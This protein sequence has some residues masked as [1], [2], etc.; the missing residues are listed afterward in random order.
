M[1]PKPKETPN[2]LLEF[3]SQLDPGGAGEECE[4]HYGCSCVIRKGQEAAKMLIAVQGIV[5]VGAPAAAAPAAGAPKESD[6]SAAAEELAQ[7]QAEMDRLLVQNME[8]TAENKGLKEKLAILQKQVERL[9]NKNEMST[10]LKRLE[11]KK[12]TEVEKA[13]DESAPGSE[14]PA[15]AA[16]SKPEEPKAEAKSEEAPVSKTEPTESD[17]GNDKG[18]ATNKELQEALSYEAVAR[19][20]KEEKEKDAAKA[21]ES[22]KD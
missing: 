17:K 11:G 2:S 18:K 1:A 19:V 15:S 16:E 10:T 21:A 13:G 4:L 9:Y 8:L 22:K 12:L 5:G 7:A 3:F 6:G 20:P 14:Q